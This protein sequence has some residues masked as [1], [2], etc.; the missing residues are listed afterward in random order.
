[1][2]LDEAASR[3]AI[4]QHVG[5]PLGLSAEA[6]AQGILAIADNDM[7]GAIRVISVER[8]HDPRDFALIPFGG[9]GPLHGSSLA[10]LLGAQTVVVPP[11][12]GVLSA[13]GLLVS[14]LRADYSRT[15]FQAPPDFDFN[16]METAFRELEAEAANWF[17]REGVLK[18]RDNS[19]AKQ[20]CV[21]SIKVSN[22][23]LI[24]QETPL[25]RKQPP[26]RSTRSIHCTSASIPLPKKTRQSRS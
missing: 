17:E 6:A 15:C 21:T 8:G 20:A 7:V 9:A 2:Q 16:L 13:M 14:Q 25:R 5:R 19:H 18:P 3:K 26:L 10:R 22:L 24:G 11:S 4:E 1:M 23:T 12:P